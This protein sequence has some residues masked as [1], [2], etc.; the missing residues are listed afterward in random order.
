MKPFTSKKKHASRM[1]S[2]AKLPIDALQG[3]DVC[4]RECCIYG[5]MQ[6]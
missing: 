5:F 2:Y 4:S 1:I 3:T 6:Q